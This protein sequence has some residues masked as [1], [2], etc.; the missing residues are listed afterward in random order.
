[1]KADRIPTCSLDIRFG[2]PIE[3]KQDA[4]NMLSDAGFSCHAST[5]STSIGPH[6]RFKDWSRLLA[7]PSGLLWH[8][9]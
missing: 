2:S 4:M 9:S 8:Q 5:S 1:M 6:D 7:R 3:G